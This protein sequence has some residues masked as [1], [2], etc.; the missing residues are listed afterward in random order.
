MLNEN[1][2]TIRIFF[3]LFHHY[4]DQNNQVRKTMDEVSLICIP[5]LQPSTSLQTLMHPF[6]KLQ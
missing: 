6:I 1:S 4:I 3:C 5:A 2:V